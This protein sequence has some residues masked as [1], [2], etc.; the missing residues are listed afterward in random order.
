M[1]KEG[2]PLAAALE[3]AFCTSTDTDT[4][5]AWNEQRTLLL[6]RLLRELLYP[7]LAKELKEVLRREAQQVLVAECARRLRVMAV[8]AA[9]ARIKEEHVKP[10]HEVPRG[11]KKKSRRQEEEERG[12]DDPWRPSALVPNQTTADGEPMARKEG[13][14][15][16]PRAARVVGMCVNVEDKEAELAAVNEA[17]ELVDTFKCRWLMTNIRARRDGGGASALDVER[18][19]G[20]LDR[21]A[22]FM[23]ETTH[24]QPQPLYPTP[25]PNLN[26]HP[27]PQPLYPTPD[28]DPFLLTTDPH[29]HPSPAPHPHPNPSSDPFPFP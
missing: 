24:R 27:N 6:A 19:L 26:P 18:K 3:A 9:P 13:A 16:Y 15:W 25:T 28:P 5:A 1:A 10:E 4:S 23:Q 22:L 20:E 11:K 14:E 7:H 12:R 21:L 29:P 17:G 2:D 8:D